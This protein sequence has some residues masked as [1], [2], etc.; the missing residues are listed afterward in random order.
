MSNLFNLLNKFQYV[1][2]SVIDLGLDGPTSL[3]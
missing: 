1:T 3:V 2:T